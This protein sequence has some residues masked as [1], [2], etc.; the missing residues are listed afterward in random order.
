MEL[1]EEILS[2]KE[3]NKR[4]RMAVTAI[5]VNN[6]ISSKTGL[7]ES[8]GVK[9]AKFSE[10]LNGRMNVGVDMI[11][12]MCDFY[13]VSPDW[14]LLSRGNNVF[15]QIAKQAIWIDDDNLNMKC[16][17]NE[18]SD[19]KIPEES[20]VGDVP[21][22]VPT[23]K[24]DDSILYNMY[25]DEKAEKEKLRLEKEA[26]IEELNAKML[27]MSEEIGRL[28]ARLGEKEVNEQNS[29][30]AKVSEAFISESSGGYGEDS[31]PTRHPTTSKRSSAGKI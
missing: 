1:Y 11:A 3:I 24:P 31:S 4:F 16:A 25:K 10:I 12:R 20:K 6:L 17:E 13:E 22:A 29:M 9:P 7:A 23:S 14:L 5:M 26:K 21:S 18:M 15:R 27:T 19:S 30:I 8:L 28:K 2:K